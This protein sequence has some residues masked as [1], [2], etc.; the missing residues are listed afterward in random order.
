MRRVLIFLV[1][2]LTSIVSFA[3]TKIEYDCQFK[4]HHPALFHQRE[5]MSVVVRDGFSFR[6]FDPQ[7]DLAEDG[8]LKAASNVLRFPES[9]IAHKGT[10]SIS[11]SSD[12]LSSP[13]NATFDVVLDLG[14]IPPVFGKTHRPPETDNFVAK[15]SWTTVEPA[16]GDPK[17]MGLCYYRETYHEVTCVLDNTLPGAA[18]RMSFPVRENSRGRTLVL[19][20]R[21]ISLGNNHIAYYGEGLLGN[22]VETMNSLNDFCE[23]RAET[24]K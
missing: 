11:Y 21:V 22:S 13:S 3:T 14:S 7:K 10:V 23:V 17:R 18:L 20:H 1:V 15:A 5:V 12:L 19:G 4:M 24:I 2:K 8:G 9:M 6:V 16:P